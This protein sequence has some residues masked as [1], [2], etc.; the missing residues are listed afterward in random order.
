MTIKFRNKIKIV[1]KRG[2]RLLKQ[3]EK[4]EVVLNSKFYNHEYLKE[5]G[6]MLIVNNLVILYMFVSIFQTNLPIVFLKNRDC[7]YDVLICNRQH[8]VKR[9]NQLLSNSILCE[10]SKWN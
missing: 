7:F 9:I 3:K 1:F 2:K 8:S 10:K 6:M 4:L 5:N